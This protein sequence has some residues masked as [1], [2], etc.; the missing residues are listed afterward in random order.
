M[1]GVRPSLRP[2]AAS[3]VSPPPS[4]ATTR[5]TTRP[6]APPATASL[7]TSP[8][9]LTRA[10]ETRCPSGTRIAF[11]TPPASS[12]AAKS[13]NSQPRTAPDTSERRKPKRVSGRS[14]PYRSMAS[15]Y[16]IRGN[17][18]RSTSRVARNTARTIPSTRAR[19]PSLENNSTG[20]GH[21]QG[22]RHHR[23]GLY[24][25]SGAGQS[26]MHAPPPSSSPLLP[27]RPLTS[28][29]NPTPDPGAPTQ[30]PPV[31]LTG[32]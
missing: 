30:G 4:A 1:S 32:P 13:L 18:G 22:W 9:G 8:L 2:L 11:T 3:R 25:V 19:M 16:V 21:K 29:P 17:A 23:G 20:A 26:C 10:L 12:G 6:P 7:W 27:C 5:A 14:D 28:N 31:T 15:A 24:H